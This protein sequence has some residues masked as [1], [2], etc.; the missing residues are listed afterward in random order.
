MVGFVLT[1]HGEFACGL[2]S[3][4]DMVAGNQA[5]FTIVP[6]SGDA[7]ATYGDDLKSAIAAMSDECPEG[8]LVFVD[9]LGGTPFNQAMM[10]SQDVPSMQI[11]TGTNLPMLIELLFLR[12]GA[13]LAELADQ[14]V[15]V[16]QAGIAAKSLES[17][18]APAA[19]DE[20]DEGGI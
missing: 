11:V 1:G 16:G 15:A 5:A 7:A 4:I 13:S 20:D 14:A 2:A 17:V 8:V 9:L 3:A 6:F 10:I 18:A 12:N 19:D